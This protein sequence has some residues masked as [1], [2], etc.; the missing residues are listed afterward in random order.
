MEECKNKGDPTKLK[1]ANCFSNHSAVAKVC[2]ANKMA[3]EKQQNDKK[4]RITRKESSFNNKKIQNRP[5]KNT[6]DYNLNLIIN[7]LSTLISNQNPHLI[8][9]LNHFILNNV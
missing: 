2:P 9:Q 7:L 5:E 1:C 3:Y 8:R 6:T 4:E